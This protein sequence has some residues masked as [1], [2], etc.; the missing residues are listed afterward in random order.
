MPTKI[1]WVKNSDGSQGE[2]WNPLRARNKETGKVGHYCV[3]V[4]NGCAGCYAERLQARFGNPIRYAAQDADKV[5]L[6]LD[7]KTLALPS[8]WRRPR[9]IFVCSMTDLFLEH[10]DVMDVVSVIDTIRDNPQHTFQVLTKRPVAAG[11]YLSELFADG[12]PPNMWLLTS[13][14]DQKTADQRIPELVKMKASVMGISAEPLLG[15]VNVSPWLHQLQWVIC[16]GES[17]PAAR[18]MHPDWA[19]S[20]RDQ[21]QHAGVAYFH[22]QNGE[23]GWFENMPWDAADDT[24]AGLYPGKKTVH[25]SCGRT[26]VRCGKKATGRL[27]D[28]RTWD[29]M[30]EIAR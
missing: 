3:H 26:S 19:R 22:K 27:L 14:E 7:E 1:E 30:P 12:F 23:W 15:P 28:G 2:T 17:G 11:W 4:S 16:G 5:E 21:C 29:G 8:K 9:M 13:V 20:L 6:F 24:A 18:P 10:Y 25:W